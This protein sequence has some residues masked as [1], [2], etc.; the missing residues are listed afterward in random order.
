MNSFIR[1]GIVYENRRIFNGGRHAPSYKNPTYNCAYIKLLAAVNTNE[2]KEMVW[3]LQ[4]TFGKFI[5]FDTF[6]TLVNYGFIDRETKMVGKRVKYM[7]KITEHGKS[8]L[9]EAAWSKP[10][11]DL[12][13]FVNKVKAE[14]EATLSLQLT[15]NGMA[16]M[17][18]QKFAVSLAVVMSAHPTVN[19]HLR[20]GIPYI[21]KFIALACA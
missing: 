7:Y 12:L 20:A 8:L 18:E 21:N 11:Y 4:H 14:D 17:C 9:K 13:E 6:K 16:Y 15:L 10:A 3:Y 1:N 5:N 2:G 19:K